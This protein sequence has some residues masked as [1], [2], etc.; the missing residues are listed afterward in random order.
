MLEEFAPGFYKCNNCSEPVRTLYR[1]RCYHTR[2]FVHLC[3]ECF[4]ENTTMWDE[5]QQEIDDRE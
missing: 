1:A 5:H 4:K 3:N 2:D